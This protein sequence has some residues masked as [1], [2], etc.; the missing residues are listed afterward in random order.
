MNPR[1]A[2]DF[3]KRGGPFRVKRQVDAIQWGGVVP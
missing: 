3:P 1:D 2:E